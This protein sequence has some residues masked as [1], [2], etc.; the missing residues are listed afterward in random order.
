MPGDTARPLAG[1]VAV[2]TGASKGIGRAVAEALA[3]E[4][5]SL[6]LVA[7]GEAPLEE[8]AS[9][10]RAAG[11][12]RVLA[13][14]ADVASSHDLDRIVLA[15]V[16]EFDGFDILVNNAGIG[17]VKPIEDVDDDEVDRTLAVNLRAPYLLCQAAVKVMR[18]RKG[19]QIVNI[20][21]GLSYFGRAHWTLYAA[22]KFGLRGLTES[23]RHEVSD[24]DIKVCLVAPGYTRTHFFDDVQGEHDFTHALAPE[25]VA[26]AVMAVVGQPPGSDI[27]EVQVRN[28]LSP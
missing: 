8:A 13:L 2:V 17:D 6:L 14:S 23:L 27:K 18:R 3:G 25:D 21:S 20:G 16:R 5:V 9:A 22:T 11:S 1:K 26:H 19:G 24:Q 4:G 15:A 10:C 12:P 28:K 7:R